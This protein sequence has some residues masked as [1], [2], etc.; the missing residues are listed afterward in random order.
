MSETT[1]TLQARTGEALTMTMDQFTETAA[2][3][4]G[5]SLEVTRVRYRGAGLEVQWRTSPRDG[6]S[7]VHELASDEPPEPEF[8]EALMKLVPPLLRLLGLSQEWAEGLVPQTITCKY[9]E[10]G[11]G[12][13]ITSM[14]RLEGINAPLV[15]NTPYLAERGETTREI[16]HDLE[17]AVN[18]VLYRAERY[19]QG[20][21]EQASLFEDSQEAA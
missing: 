7:I 13:V 3:I 10:N 21:R 15:I 19:V 11:W 16:P 9:E 6:E 20:H 5:P 8:I 2:A 4:A 1:V 18:R 12:V 14:K 17:R